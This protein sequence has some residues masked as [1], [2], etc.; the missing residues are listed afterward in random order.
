L[1]A[2]RDFLTGF[3]VVAMDQSTIGKLRML[4]REPEGRAGA[5]YQPRGSTALADL[6]AILGATCPDGSTHVSG[7]GS[8]RH[9][10]ESLQ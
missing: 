4:H 6:S 1:A 3:L 9:T 7:L 8:V 2:I 5:V 10:M